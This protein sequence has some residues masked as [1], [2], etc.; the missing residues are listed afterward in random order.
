MI[1]FVKGDSVAKGVRHM[2]MRMWFTREKHEK[3]ENE[4]KL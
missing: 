3:L 2:E 4:I 1:D